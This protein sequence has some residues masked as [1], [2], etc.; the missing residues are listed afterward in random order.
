ME[1]VNVSETSIYV[2]G[3]TRRDITEGCPLHTRRRENMKSHPI[4]AIYITSNIL[5]TVPKAGMALVG[6]ADAIGMPC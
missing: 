5:I 2:Y 4:S 3:S 6:H 1:A